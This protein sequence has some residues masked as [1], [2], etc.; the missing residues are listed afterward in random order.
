MNKYQESVDTLI[1]DEIT[2]EKT[3]VLLSKVLRYASEFNL[4]DLDLVYK[5][6]LVEQLQG[7]NAYQESIHVPAG[8]ASPHLIDWTPELASMYGAFASIEVWQI[9]SDLEFSKEVVPIKMT[10]TADK[11]QA[12]SYQIELSGFESIIIIK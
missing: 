12:V 10:T 6:Y 8:S 11:L 3:L 2:S 7:S 1:T 5:K 9:I 4:Q